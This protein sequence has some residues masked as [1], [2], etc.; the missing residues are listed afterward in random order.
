MNCLIKR[1]RSCRNL[2]ARMNKSKM[3]R[4]VVIEWLAGDRATEGCVCDG[5]GV[6]LPA[7]ATLVALVV[8]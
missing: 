3:G 6:M 1:L 5:F 8:F 2:L 7:A 4:N